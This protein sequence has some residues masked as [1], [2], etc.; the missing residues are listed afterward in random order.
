LFHHKQSFQWFLRDTEDIGVWVDEQMQTATDEA[1]N[2]PINL[3]VLM[4]WLPSCV[5][6]Y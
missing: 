4:R 5:A 2:D 3:K 1:C 6:F